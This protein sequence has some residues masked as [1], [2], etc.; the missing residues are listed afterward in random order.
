MLTIGGTGVGAELGTGAA[1]VFWLTPVGDGP[2]GVAGVWVEAGGVA[3]V[4]AR[5]AV[6]R[7]GTARNAAPARRTNRIHKLLRTTGPAAK[8]RETHAISQEAYTA[9]PLRLVKLKF[10]VF[11]QCFLF[12]ARKPQLSLLL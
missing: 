1:V 3:A 9:T 12:V 7:A 8:P 11:A 2:D 10:C 5:T 4:C 6:E